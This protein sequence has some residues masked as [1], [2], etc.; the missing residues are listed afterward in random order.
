MIQ[1][2]NPNPRSAR[3]TSARLSPGW[4]RCPLPYAA[5]RVCT[6]WTPAPTRS[7][8]CRR[9]CRSSPAC[10]PLPCARTGSP[11][12]RRSWAASRSC[13]RWTRAR[14][15]S[16]ACRAL[17]GLQQ[18]RS[19]LLD[20]NRFGLGIKALGRAPVF[21]GLELPCVREARALHGG[22]VVATNRGLC[23]DAWGSACESWL[24]P[25]HMGPAALMAAS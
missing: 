4:R 3:L 24:R 22:A 2:P 13:G 7:R 1:Y 11:A 16:P 14:T 17:G 15:G 10:A 5:C 18:L 25:W 8:R 9:P 19:L 21:D 23:R 20:G 12:C 6:R